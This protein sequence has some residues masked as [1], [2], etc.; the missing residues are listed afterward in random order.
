MSKLIKFEVVFSPTQA[1]YYPGQTIQGH[2]TVELNDTMKMRGIRLRFQGKAEVEWT[3]GSGDNEEEY[4]EKEQYFKDDILLDGRGSDASGAK[5]HLP[6]GR[7]TYPFTYQLPKDIPSSFEGKYG[8]VRYFAKGIIDKPWKFDHETMKCFTVICPL[9]LNQETLATMPAKESKSKTICCLCCQS[10]PITATFTIDRQGYVPGEAIILKA[11]IEN[12]SD[13]P[14]DS[15]S[16]TLTME[17]TFLAEGESKTTFEKVAKLQHEPILMGDHDY[18]N[19]DQLAIPPL[20]PTYLTSCT[21]IDIQYTLKLTVSPPGLSLNLDINLPVI[22]GTI[23]VQ[24]VPDRH[25]PITHPGPAAYTETIFSY[26]T[27]PAYPP[28]ESLPPGRDIFAPGAGYAP[29]PYPPEGPTAS[30]NLPP[31]SYEE[32][33]FGRVNITQKEDSEHLHGDKY[34]APVYT[35]YDWGHNATAPPE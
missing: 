32:C 4:S 26:P 9:D 20:P 6:A 16:V 2:L 28:G 30:P 27:P 17:T 12:M 11:E 10:G 35:Y 31:P 22:I 24:N 25:P 3:E 34:F 15:S 21:I 5:L 29:P 14:I 19:G 13:G 23:P 1:I 33:V 8:Y 18:W 7:H